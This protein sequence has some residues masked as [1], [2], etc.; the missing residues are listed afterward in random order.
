MGLSGKIP[1]K[2]GHNSEQPLTDGQPALG[3]VSHV[4]REGKKLLADFVDMPSVVYDAIKKG[5]Y[6]FVSVELL[7]DVT[8]DT[9]VIPWVLDAVAL[10]GADPPAVGN[11]KDLQQLTMARGSGLQGR[12]RVAFTRDTSTGGHRPNMAD[13]KDKDDIKAILAR[14]DNAERER[15]SLKLTAARAEQSETRLKELQTQTQNEKITAHR[16]KIS[17]MFDAAIKDKR[18]LPRVRESFKRAYKL[19]AES[20][21]DVPL[22]DVETFIKENPNPEAPRK[23]VGLK[24]VG[25]EPAA[26][27]RADDR[28]LHFTRQYV[29][30]NS[31]DPEFAKMP[32]WQRLHVAAQRVMAADPELGNSYKHLPATVDE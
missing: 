31:G 11:L 10:L 28:V 12:R 26:D 9:R 1:L 23:I 7:G 3:W 21:I 8:A 4:Y 14:L 6:K 15:D 29:R 2:F 5:I 18:I 20:I 19:D 32:L 24:G 13:D 25:D 22:T 16:A 30:E 27:A 17:E